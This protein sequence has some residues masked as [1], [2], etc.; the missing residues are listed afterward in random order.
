MSSSTIIYCACNQINA[1]VSHYI[2]ILSHKHLA[3][4]YF[5][6]SFECLNRTIHAILAYNTRFNANTWTPIWSCGDRKYSLSLNKLRWQE[7]D[8]QLITAS[9][10]MQCSERRISWNWKLARNAVFSPTE[11]PTNAETIEI[12][13]FTGAKIK[14]KIEEEIE[15]EIG[16]YADI[17]HLFSRQPYPMR[18]ETE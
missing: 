12:A 4:H 18:Y 7:S 10:W 5:I 17:S 11:T 15:N 3:I 14:N 16:I 2:S 1:I 13:H 9:K 8:R 6:V